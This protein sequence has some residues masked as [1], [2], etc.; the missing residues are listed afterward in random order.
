MFK[1]KFDSSPK[2]REPIES[3]QYD[4][5]CY[6]IV[7]LGHVTKFNKFKEIEERINEIVIMFEIPEL[8]FTWERDGKEVTTP[9]SMYP[10]FKVSMHEKSKLRQFISAWFNKPFPDDESAYNFDFSKLIGHCATLNVIQNGDFT[11][12]QTIGPLHKS[13]KLDKQFNESINFG[14]DDLQSPVYETLYPWIKKRIMESEEYTALAA[15]DEPGQS[16][17]ED[18][19][20]D[21]IPF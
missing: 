7:E 1:P 16:T 2:K 11:N 8:M 3:G 21:D 12:I 15:K 20:T 17:T 14:I 6:G 19:G 5:R 13:V 10:R 4:A 18:I 9:K